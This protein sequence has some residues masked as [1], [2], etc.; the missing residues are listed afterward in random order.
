MIERL[1]CAAVAC[2]LFVAAQYAG[3]QAMAVTAL[4]AVVAGWAVRPRSA[5][6]E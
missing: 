5:K 1:A 2:G 3:E 6:A 4:A